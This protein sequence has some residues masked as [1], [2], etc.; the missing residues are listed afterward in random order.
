MGSRWSEDSFAIRAVLASLVCCA[1]TAA[2]LMAP[3][4]PRASAAPPS[5]AWQTCD[6]GEPADQQCDIPRGVAADPDTGHIFVGD[7]NNLRVSEFDIWGQF[8]KAWGWDVVASG[9][10]DSGTGFEICVPAN[11]DTCKAGSE[12]SGP[13]QFRSLQGMAVDSAGNV[14]VADSPNRRVQKFS[15]AGEFLLMFGGGVNQGPSNP[16]N[17]CTAADLGVGDVCGAGAT[18]PAPNPPGQFGT[19]RVGSFIAIT[20]SDQVFVGDEQRIQRFD[21]NGVYKGEIPLPGETVQ[22]LASDSSGNL[23]VTYYDS[24]IDSKANVHKKIG[25]AH[26]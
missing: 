1:L 24:G 19:W 13:G 7:S 20:P 4:A 10:G 23:Y 11:G 6:S 12:G 3:A 9:P 18:G 15:P 21:T 26:V 17:V 2:S 22:S 16:G 25:R 14:Y 8:V 5:L